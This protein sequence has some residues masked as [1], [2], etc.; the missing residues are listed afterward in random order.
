[1]INLMNKERLVAANA[2][3]SHLRDRPPGWNDVPSAAL[4][5]KKHTHTYGDEEM[6]ASARRR[7]MEY[8]FY[9]I[10]AVPMGMFLP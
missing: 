2:G 9:P 4:G 10:G 5:K 7:G 6:S 8:Y 3:A 1:M